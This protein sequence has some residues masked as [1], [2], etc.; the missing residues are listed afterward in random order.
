[1]FGKDIWTKNISVLVKKYP[2]IPVIDQWVNKEKKD[3]REWKL[4]NGRNQRKLYQI[5]LLTK[6]GRP[7]S[8]ELL[9]EVF[10]FIGNSKSTNT[11]QST[12]DPN[13]IQPSPS[14]SEFPLRVYD[15]RSGVTTV[16]VDHHEWKWRNWGQS[17]N[18]PPTDVKKTEYGWSFITDEMEYWKVIWTLSREHFSDIRFKVYIVNHDREWFGFYHILGGLI[19]KDFAWWRVESP[20]ILYDFPDDVWDKPLDY[21]IKKYK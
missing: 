2:D 19:Q 13:C 14:E 11:D 4:Q 7:L 5:V 18:S 8:K 9:N 20:G 17:K 16:Y 1:V 21:I 10:Q 15:R 6:G 12:F 3:L